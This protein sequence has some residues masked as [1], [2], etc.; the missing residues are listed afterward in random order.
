MD[1]GK[2]FAHGLCT[3]RSFAR[4]HFL[5]GWHLAS[6]WLSYLVDQV[7]AR[8]HRRP[9]AQR[10][11]RHP[12]QAVIAVRRQRVRS[13]ARP[14]LERRQPVH[15]IVRAVRRHPRRIDRL[16]PITIQIK[17]L[18]G[19]GLSL[20][21]HLASYWLSHYTIQIITVAAHMP[22]LVGEACRGVIFC[23]VGISPTSGCLI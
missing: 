18:H 12:A 1:A 23:L 3:R 11:L 21:W 5:L 14:I 4:P 6:Y 15:D 17:E 20:H 13:L 8:R 19:F 2:P 10:H 16:R 9:V 22:R 7:I